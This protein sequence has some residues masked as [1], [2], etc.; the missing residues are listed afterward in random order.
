MPVDFD[1]ATRVHLRV[2]NGLCIFRVIVVAMPI[3]SHSFHELSR[4]LDRKEISALELVGEFVAKIES[5]NGHY[6]AVRELNPAAESI[7]SLLDEER[8]QGIIRSPLHGIPILL[9]DAFP[10]ADEMCT[11]YGVAALENLKTSFD[12]AIADSLRQSGAII[13]GK[14]SCTDFGDYMSSTMPAEH[15]T[16]GGT[17]INPLGVRYGRGGGS[18]TGCAAAVAAGFAPIAIGS[19]AQNSIQGPSANS[20]LVGLKPTVGALK[21]T[22]EP[23]LVKSHTT[24]GPMG[25]SVT[26]VAWI[27]SLLM[28]PAAS[29]RLSQ[30]L[31]STLEQQAFRVGVVRRGVLG[32]TGM[33][34]YDDAYD[35]ALSAVGMGNIEF[36]DPADIETMDEVLETHSSV[37]KTEFK[38]GIEQLLSTPGINCEQQ[39]L[40]DIIRFND[41]NQERAI[42]YGQDLITAAEQTVNQPM[43]QYYDDRARDIRLT[44]DEGI[45]ATLKANGLNALVAPMDFAAKLTGKAGYPVLTL[46]CGDTADGKPFALSF[47]AGSFQEH[48]LVKLG[49]A[50]EA[51]QGK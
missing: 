40:G 6:N 42:P 51:I 21:E 27:L 15:S 50:V 47:I 34:A 30:L 20:G 39:T 18:S 35:N 2:I 43:S 44:R 5:Q 4:S 36:V 13:L 12:S 9:K 19:E 16:T 26:D 3:I 8:A 33:Q 32:R 1:L 14:C 31:T 48:T 24:A 38:Q 41:S 28:K 49:L 10:T 37:F 45:D 23:S 11:T 22:P 29:T 46:P 17:V 7:A 25:H